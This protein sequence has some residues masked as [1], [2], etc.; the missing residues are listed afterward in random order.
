MQH[1]SVPTTTTENHDIHSNW[2]KTTRADTPIVT[3]TLKNLSLLY[4]QQGRYDAADILENYALNTRND[5]Q[6]IIQALD[7][8]RQIN[9]P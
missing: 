3:K 7:I 2:Y 9:N 5:S 1:L 8:V 4:R 6:T